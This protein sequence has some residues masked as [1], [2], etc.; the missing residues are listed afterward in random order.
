[1]K[2]K[3]NIRNALNSDWENILTADNVELNTSNISSV[4]V[5]DAVGELYNRDSYI[6]SKIKS[7]LYSEYNDIAKSR[8]ISLL[9]S[10][11][12][13]TI[14]SNHN[15]NK[16]YYNGSYLT[17][18]NKGDVYTISS[19]SA[20]DYF[21]SEKG[22]NI[23]AGGS[24]NHF[25]CVPLAYSDKT[26]IIPVPRSENVLSIHVLSVDSKC[27]VNISSSAGVVHTFDIDAYSVHTFDTNTLSN[28]YDVYEVSSDNN[29]IVFYSTNN[30]GSD[31]LVVPPP[32]SEI[33]GWC[34]SYS[35][36]TPLYDN[37]TIKIYGQ[38]GS[39]ISLTLDKWE[40]Y[41]ISGIGQYAPSDIRHVI[42]DK[43]ICSIS[44]GDGDG[45][46]G[47][48]FH[49]VNLYLSYNFS[50]PGEIIANQQISIAS[51][52]PSSFVL[53]DYSGNIL[54]RNTLTTTVYNDEYPFGYRYTATANVS[55][56][57][58]VECSDPCMVVIDTGTDPDE[59][60]LYGSRKDD[61][62]TGIV[63]ISESG[64]YGWRLYDYIPGFY[65]DIGNHAVDISYSD[66]LS[67]NGA[68]GDYS[69][70]CGYNTISQNDYQFSAGKFNVGTYTNTVFE[71]GIGISDND[72]KNALEIYTDGTV[73]TPEA[74]T[75]KN[76][77][78]GL[79]TVSSIQ[80]IHYFRGS[81]YHYIFGNNDW[82]DYIYYRDPLSSNVSYD[83]NSNGVVITSTTNQTW[84]K[85][86]TRI[87]IDP[88]ASYFMRLRM[89]KLSGDGSF[90]A[91]AISLD[92]NYN[93][94]FTDGVNKYNYFCARNVVV[95]SGSQEEFIGFISGYNTI[96]ETNS[97]KFDPSA[98]Y[99]DIVIITD[100]L[101]TVSNSSTVI[102]SV[103]LYKTPHKDTYVDQYKVFHAGNSRFLHTQSTASDTWV[104]NHNLGYQ[105]VNI[106][107]FDFTDER[108]MPAS[109]IYDSNVQSTI[110]FNS[111][112][113]GKALVSL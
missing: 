37:T 27:T 65:G 86:R 113:T 7:R 90:Y 17:T 44:V 1:M 74:D 9:D 63:K 79:N 85:L 64:N 43:P 48:A 111:P 18:L 16:V 110:T 66:V 82:T 49:P 95:P 14:T 5:N 34:S 42:S 105:Y 11:S 3:L 78:R 67:Q 102:E 19:I 101:N 89:K 76:V 103:E 104:I 45:Y 50:I 4:N 54:A 22:I 36:V 57:A 8:Q 59:Q 46:N 15:N 10:T 100:Y 93:E 31:L 83:N 68:I 75:S 30:A 51:L 92:S 2:Y 109:I 20:G 56:G 47:T 25:A 94:M 60:V 106:S 55:A 98:S 40:S 23:R 52:K 77:S 69:V 39:Y 99:F 73:V 13:C 91:G 87:P 21:D 112:I 62:S 88:D 71:Y 70:S 61:T 12:G 53:R 35:N 41:T 24:A 80:D 72:R 84:I 29:V 33:I 6:E 108:I 58:Y 28:S 96:T 81:A 97:H 107:V 26:F 38:D 32:S